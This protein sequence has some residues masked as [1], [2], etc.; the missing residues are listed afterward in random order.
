MTSKFSVIKFCI[1]DFQE[2]QTTKSDVLE[3]AMVN[4]LKYVKK[5]IQKMILVRIDH[6]DFRL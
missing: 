1:G 3:S 4:S 5:D 2:I 6:D